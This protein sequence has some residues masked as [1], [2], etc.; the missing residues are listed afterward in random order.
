V[1]HCGLGGAWQVAMSASAVRWPTTGALRT[2]PAAAPLTL[3]AR[4]RGSSEQVARLGD[5]DEDL[6]E[7]WPLTPDQ[8]QGL[9]VRLLGHVPNITHW[10][11]D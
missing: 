10:V 1:R 3:Y 6:I 8:A 11:E 7:R 2:S 4:R 5:A 9:A